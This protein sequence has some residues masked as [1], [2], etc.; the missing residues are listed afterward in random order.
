M[1]KKTK[2]GKNELLED[3]R[4]LDRM[5]KGLA[6]HQKNIQTISKRISKKVDA[7]FRSGLI[8]NLDIVASHMRRAMM[9]LERAKKELKGI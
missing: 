3:Y 5:S 1:A 2:V 8:E 7:D 4:M 9:E 6:V